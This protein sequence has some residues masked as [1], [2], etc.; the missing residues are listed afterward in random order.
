META[1][2]LNTGLAHVMFNPH[3]GAKQL[4][5]SLCVLR[6]KEVEG[7]DQGHRSSKRLTKNV[8]P[9]LTTK[10]TLFHYTKLPSSQDEADSL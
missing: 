10:T 3:T 4:L 9:S 6:P 1:Y 2:E 8:N 7:M 5:L